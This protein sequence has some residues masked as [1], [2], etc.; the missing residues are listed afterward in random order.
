M[1]KFL[2][3]LIFYL[4]ANQVYAQDLFKTL[5]DAFKKNSKLNAQRAS[6]NASEQEVNIS[7]GDFLPS[8][9]LSG[10]KATQ[11]D[12]DRKNLSGE[13]LLDTHSTPETRSVLVEQKIFDGFSNYNNLKKSKLELEYA[14]FELN[15]L[16]QEILLSAA[17][18]YYSLG[19]YFKNFEFNQCHPKNCFFT[20]PKFTICLQFST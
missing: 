10:D 19:Y 6:L 18:A 1:K 13:S 15:K 7:R 20:Y 9:T 4:F 14:K 3:L 17:E 8:V 12:T 11:K 5:S 16:E 2:I